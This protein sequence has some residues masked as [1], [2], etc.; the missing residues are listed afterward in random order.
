MICVSIAGVNA[1]EAC[2]IIRENE[3]SEVRLDLIDF[4]DRDLER[5]FSSGKTVAT[6]RQLENLDN[7]R[8]KDILISAIKHGATYV[9]IEVENSDAFKL[10]LKE[11][12]S[13]AGCKTIVSYHDYEKTPAMR[14]LEQIITWCFEGGADLAKIACKAESAADAA[15]LLSLYSLGKPVISIGM[16]EAGRITRVAAPLL[17][18]PFTYASLDSARETAPGQIDSVTLAKIID[19]IRKPQ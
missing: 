4:A 7:S 2:R 15:R 10:E 12:A 3:L 18:A 13:L 9:D 11:A 6:H 19:L 17:G 16:G 5:I 8:R 1:D 14:E